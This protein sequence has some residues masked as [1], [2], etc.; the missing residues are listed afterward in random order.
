MG[1]DVETELTLQALYRGLVIK[2]VQAAYGTRP[3][4]SFSKLK[5][6]SDGMLVLLKLFL[7]IKSY[8]PLTF[9]GGLGIFFMLA[10]LLV[11]IR[12][13]YEYVAEHSVHAVAERDP[14]VVAG[15]AFVPQPGTGPDS[16]QR[17]PAAAGG[18]KAH[19]QMGREGHGQA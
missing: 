2:E 5:T 11:G 17:Q 1:F 13:V 4:G 10:G 19:P 6:G 14:G 12:P 7:M 8:K 3:D 16:E 15:D 9:F 18:G